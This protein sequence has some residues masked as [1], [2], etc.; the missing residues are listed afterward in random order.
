MKVSGISEVAVSRSCCVKSRRDA[1]IVLT[2]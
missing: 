1:L 2:K